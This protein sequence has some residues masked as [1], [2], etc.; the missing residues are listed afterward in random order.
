MIKELHYKTNIT[1]TGNRGLG[2]TDYAA[3]DRS[4]EIKINH[5]INISGSSDAP[6]RGDIN[7]HNPEDLFLSSIS[8]CHMLWF[9][10]LCADKGIVVVAYE[11]D[12]QGTMIE[13]PGGGGKFTSV[14][15]NPKVIITDGKLIEVVNQLH[16]EA[17]KKCFIANSCNFTIHHNPVCT[18]ITK[19]N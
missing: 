14:I 3:Y 16:V 15:L 12:A 17:N 4:Y 13:T 9:L 1:W 5:K 8:S 19:Y 2:T 18:V 10:H 11:D 7:K 6:F